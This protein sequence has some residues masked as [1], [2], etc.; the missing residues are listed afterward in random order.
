[1]LFSD[2]G[3]EVLEAEAERIRKDLKLDPEK[4][5]THWPGCWA[6][7]A[8][9]TISLIEDLIA[10]LREARPGPATEGENCISTATVNF[11][12]GDVEIRCT[13][14]GEHGMHRCEV[15][16]PLA[17]DRVDETGYV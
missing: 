8:G 4:Q 5:S 17:E 16:W 6:S 14:T 13:E 11:G 2:H 7:H 1:M 12:G 15:W 9:C 3:L 10:D